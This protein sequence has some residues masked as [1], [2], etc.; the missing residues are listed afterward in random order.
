MFILFFRFLK[1]FVSNDDAASVRAFLELSSEIDVLNYCDRNQPSLLHLAAKNNFVDVANLLLRAKA[2]ANQAFERLET[3]L[4][5]AV[6]CGHDQ[7]VRLLLEQPEIE[8]DW[9]DEWQLTALV[10]ALVSG[11]SSIVQQLLQANASVEKGF[12]SASTQG[13]CQTVEFLLQQKADVNFIDWSG[14]FALNVA[15][16]EGHDNVISLLLNAN[17][18]VNQADK[19][20]HSPLMSAALAGKLSSVRLLLAANANVHQRSFHQETALHRASVRGHSAVVDELLSAGADPNAVD[21]LGRTAL[22]NVSKWHCDTGIILSLLSAKADINLGDKKGD[23]PLMY[24]ILYQHPP[25]VKVLLDHGADWLKKGHAT[26]SARQLARKSSAEIQSL[27]DC[28]LCG[29]EGMCCVT[30]RQKYCVNECDKLLGIGRD[31]STFV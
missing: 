17:A 31:Q 25:A 11:H 23:T 5:A 12:V 18:T 29:W 6:Q 30:C 19:R 28:S 7:M 21:D 9:Q 13:Q 8:V 3:P 22:S 20:G 15:A 10:F 24:A 14:N 26:R 4:I 27:F 1:I 2:D 16:F